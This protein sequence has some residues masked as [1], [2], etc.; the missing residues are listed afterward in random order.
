MNALRMDVPIVPYLMCS[1]EPTEVD[2]TLVVNYGQIVQIVTQVYARIAQIHICWMELFAPSVQ[3]SFRTALIV[4]W[5]NASTVRAITS[6]KIISARPVG[7][8]IPTAWPATNPI[9]LTALITTLFKAQIVSH[10]I[11]NGSFAWSATKRNVSGA[12]TCIMP[13][14]LS[15]FS[16]VC[17]GSVVIRAMFHMA[18]SPAYILMESATIPV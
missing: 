14:E 18:V 7:N 17:N 9:A 16:A 8:F 4:L 1:T 2:A 15:V 3:N 11:I 5:V 10:V 6:W 13:M 12:K